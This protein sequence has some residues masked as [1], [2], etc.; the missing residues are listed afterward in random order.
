MIPGLNKVFKTVSNLFSGAGSNPWLNAA[1][2][3]GSEYMHHEAMLKNQ[4]LVNAFNAEQALL[5]RQ[6]EA[7][8]AGIY[9]DWTSDEGATARDFNRIEALRARLFSQ[10]EAFKARSFSAREAIRARKF[11]MREAQK[12]RRWQR[13]MSDTAITRQMR[14]MRRAGIN[15]ILAGKYGGAPMGSGSAAS[16]PAASGP[17]AS[18]PAASTSIP[19][20]ASARGVAA[21][22]VMANLPN[23]GLNAIE[24]FQAMRKLEMEE[25]AQ[26]SGA[27]LQSAQASKA[28]AEAGL[29][30]FQKRKLTTEIALNTA[31]TAT[32]SQK[33]VSEMFR[34][35]EIAKNLEV[36]SAT[37]KWKRMESK[38][39]EQKVDLGAFEQ[40]AMNYINILIDDGMSAAIT[41]VDKSGLPKLWKEII[42]YALDNYPK[43][44]YT[45]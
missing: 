24:R 7:E 8:Q 20:A 14:D 22:G 4:E 9:R 13:S 11:N 42:R 10:R 38:L 16:G 45:R 41:A 3:V 17:A 15:P 21:R 40:N 5:Q 33:R 43:R 25:R 2:T 23:I 35:A 6:F 31:K 12:H 18:G 37:A 27:M 19:T 36:L 28:L 32:E 1:G 44:R 26:F 30:A 34:T 29:P 39:V